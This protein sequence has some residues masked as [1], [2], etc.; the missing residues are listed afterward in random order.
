MASSKIHK[1]QQT[2]PKKSDH[3]QDIKIKSLFFPHYEITRLR[4][5][6]LNSPSKWNWFRSYIF[7][8]KLYWPIDCAKFHFW[9]SMLPIVQTRNKIHILIS[10]SGLM[11]HLNDSTCLQCAMLRGKNLCVRAH[12]HTR[13]SV[14][15]RCIQ[16]NH[17]SIDSSIKPNY[18]MRTSIKT[19]MFRMC[20]MP[21]GINGEILFFLIYDR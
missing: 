15:F 1:C 20:P 13:F 11:D 17:R 19:A 18:N 5:H 2:R 3:N 16:L 6:F 9:T 8:G 7:F 21:K 4:L 10:D 12:T 14:Q